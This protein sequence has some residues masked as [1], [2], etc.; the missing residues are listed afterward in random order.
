MSRYLIGE[1]DDNPRITV[2]PCSEVVDGGDGRLEWLDVRD[3]T[4]GAVHRREA[5]GLFLLLGAEPHCDWLPESVV[6]DDNGFV[7]TG[8]DVPPGA[9]A[10]RAPAGHAGDHGA[11]HLRR[12]RRSFRFDEAGGGGQWRGRL[13]GAAG[14]RLGRVA[15]LKPAGLAALLGQL[16]AVRRVGAGS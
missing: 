4:T 16:V 8:R 1:I 15:A 12:R 14:A 10:R 9:V 7:L 3:I 6:R 11:R 2:L 5:R 13:R